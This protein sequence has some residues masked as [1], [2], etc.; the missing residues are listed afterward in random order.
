MN[1]FDNYIFYSIC[2]KSYELYKKGHFRNYHSFCNTLKSSIILE[3]FSSGEK[4]L[5]FEI[6]LYL[7][8]LYGFDDDTIAYYTLRY[9]LGDKYR[10]F[11]ETIRLTK[12]C[13]GKLFV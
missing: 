13:F 3:S 9:F 12:E 10:I 4:A 8:K 6:N 1:R 7:K 2:D 11:E 5:L